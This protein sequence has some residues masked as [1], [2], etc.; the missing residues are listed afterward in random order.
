V[1]F[2]KDIERPTLI[3]NALDDPF[4]TPE[5]IPAENALSSHVTLEVSES[6][7]HVGFIEGGTPWRPRFYIPGRLIGFLEPL[8]ARPGM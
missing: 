4:M 3:V 6:G 1:H 2:L 8:A 7:G 5:V